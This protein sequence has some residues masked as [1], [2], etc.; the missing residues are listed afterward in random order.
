MT[1]LTAQTSP[2]LKP[3]PVPTYQAGRIVSLGRLIQE[4]FFWFLLAACA[5]AACC[6]GPGLWLRGVTFGEASLGA[7]KATLSLPMLLLGFL[8][9]SAG[10]GVQTKHLRHVLRDPKPLFAGLVAN[11]AIP[12]AFLLGV[13][14]VMSGWHDPDHAG[15]ILVGLALI[16]SMPVASTSTLWSQ[17]ADGNLA[18][19]L[20]LVLLSTLLSPLTT[21]A[22]FLAGGLLAPGNYASIFYDLGEKDA[23]AF[24]TMAVIVPSA[25][26]LACKG[27]LGEAR[28]TPAKP[29]LKLLSSTSLLVLTYANASAALPRILANPDLSFL[30]VALGIVAGLCVTAFAAGW[31][32]SRL[33]RADRGQQTALIFGLG[34][35]SNAVGLVLASATVVSHPL[36]IVPILLHTLVQQLVAGAARPLLSRMVRSSALT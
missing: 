21:P 35:N 18:L 8:L 36:V 15:S 2:S 6:P 13:S 27:I 14:Q 28:V 20:G 3:S 30:A 32:I 1:I 22:V 5:A 9:F 33:L 29:L 23:R 16:A 34:M 26:G 19:S 4:R 25:L 24:L 17:N 12:V 11:L 7:E 10:L 31:G